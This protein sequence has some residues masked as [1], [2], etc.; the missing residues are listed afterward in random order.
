MVLI[1]AT[2]IN[3]LH[4]ITMFILRS[5]LSILG[6]N[7]KVTGMLATKVTFTIG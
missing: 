4:D 7:G 6:V 2:Y 3:Y 5:F 1:V